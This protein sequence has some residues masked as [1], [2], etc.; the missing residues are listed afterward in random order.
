MRRG[1]GATTGNRFRHYARCGKS[2]EAH[3]IMKEDFT[4]GRFPSQLFGANAA[5][6]ALM[7]LSLNLQMVMKRTVLGTAFLTKRMKA[8]RFEMITHGGR[9]LFHARNQILRVS[10]AFADQLLA[11]RATLDALRTAPA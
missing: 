4:G 7:L 5:W 9:L 1:S 6:W 8:V 11:W 2:E 3:A 10:Q